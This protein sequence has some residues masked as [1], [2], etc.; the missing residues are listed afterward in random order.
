M[1][2]A[3]VVGSLNLDTSI[4]LERMPQPGAVSYTHLGFFTS[5]LVEHIIFGRK[6]QGLHPRQVA[7]L[8]LWGSRFFCPRFALTSILSP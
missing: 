2:K 6:T 1:C 3:V 8:T 5:L 4:T 7:N